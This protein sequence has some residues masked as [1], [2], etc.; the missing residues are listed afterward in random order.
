MPSHIKVGGAWRKESGSYVKVGGA[1]RKGTMYVKQGGVWRSAKSEPVLMN[2]QTEY[3]AGRI[4]VTNT[5]MGDVETNI[6]VEISANEAR[7]YS[8]KMDHLPNIKLNYHNPQIVRFTASSNYGKSSYEWGFGVVLIYA[9]HSGAQ[10]TITMSA[11]ENRTY[12]SSNQVNNKMSVATKNTYGINDTN[13]NSTTANRLSAISQPTLVE[14]FTFE[15]NVPNRTMRVHNH[16][17]NLPSDFSYAYQIWVMPHGWYSTN[18]S[19]DTRVSNLYI[20]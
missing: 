8:R 18:Y 6:G 9:N 3:N 2:I 13:H 16:T 20:L 12:Y 17:I 7:G 15:L 1:W 19:C 11:Y 5:A 10:Q 4:K 14:T